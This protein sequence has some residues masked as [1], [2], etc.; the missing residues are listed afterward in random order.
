MLTRA[1]NKNIV[2]F[3]PSENRESNEF[4][5][6]SFFTKTIIEK[7]RLKSVLASKRL[8]IGGEALSNKNTISYLVRAI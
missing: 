3:P 1:N 5:K 2:N 8:V 6:Y 4:E 7:E